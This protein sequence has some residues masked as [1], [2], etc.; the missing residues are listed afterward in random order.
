MILL[1]N[2]IKHLKWTGNGRGGMTNFILYPYKFNLIESIQKN[3]TRCIPFG[4]KFNLYLVI[5]DELSDW[6]P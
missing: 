4:C 3:I 1:I 6:I 5:P 2:W